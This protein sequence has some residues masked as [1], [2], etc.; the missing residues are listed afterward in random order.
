VGGPLLADAA[1]K[2]AERLSHKVN[3]RGRF[4]HRRI[5]KAEQRLFQM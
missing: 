1:E 4:F 5:E 2:V 3:L